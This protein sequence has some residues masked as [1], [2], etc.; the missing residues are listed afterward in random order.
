VVKPVSTKRNVLTYGVVTVV[1]QVVGFISGIVTTR[2]LGDAGRGEWQKMLTWHITLSLI[3]VMGVPNGLLVKLK[4]KPE[5]ARRY[6]SMAFVL[7]LIWAIFLIVTGVLVFSFL[8]FISHSYAPWMRTASQYLMILSIFAV[9][10]PIVQAYDIANNNFERVNKVRAAYG[11]SVQIILLCL[12]PMGLLTSKVYAYTFTLIGIF[13]AIYLF[14]VY[15]RTVGFD[16]TEAKKTLSDLLASILRFSTM[17]L[18]NIA[19]AQIDSIVVNMAF[20]SKTS[21]HYGLGLNLAQSLN[22]IQTALVF[23]LLPKG[24]ERS[25]EEMKEMMLRVTRVTALVL[26]VV[27]PPLFVLIP[28]F[29]QLVY[30]FD[31]VTATISQIFFVGVFFLILARLLSQIPAAMEKPQ[32]SSVCQVAGLAVTIPLLF[33]LGAQYNTIGISIAMSVGYFIQFI[34]I[35]IVLNKYFSISW[36][37]FIPKIADVRWLLLYITHRGKGKAIS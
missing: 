5:E 7:V 10:I 4:Q 33:Y 17:D 34:T 25:T 6:I 9:I 22:A 14:I 31:I 26:L 29:I 13:F 21:G 18:V 19:N 1:V 11:L 27:I 37:R 16:F 35:C 24:L 2:A 36:N 23:V 32:Y 20:S 8:P 30:Q 12:A 28:F 15:V 3:M